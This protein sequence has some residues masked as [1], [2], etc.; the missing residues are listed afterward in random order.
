MGYN[1][2][3]KLFSR[4]KQEP[5]SEV[6]EEIEEHEVVEDEHSLVSISM[7]YN[8]EM[9]I[10]ISCIW[11]DK[12]DEASFLL[13]DLL[14]KIDSGIAA[15]YITNILIKHVSNEPSE[16]EFVAGVFSMY[17]TMKKHSEEEQPLVR[18]SDVFRS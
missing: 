4:S 9:D 3:R 6:L 13:A 2:F 8:A 14:H 10:D 16:S 17:E 1:I 18:P 5:E 11:K 7:S 12:T 15:T